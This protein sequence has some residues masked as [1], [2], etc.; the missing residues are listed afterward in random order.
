MADDSH[1][2]TEPVKDSCPVSVG[3][4]LE[5]NIEVTEDGILEKSPT[6]HD[7]TMSASVALDPAAQRRLVWKF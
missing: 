7:R 1:D 6:G 4:G 5:K 2:G 3:G